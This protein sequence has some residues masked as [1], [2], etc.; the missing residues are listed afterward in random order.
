MAWKSASAIIW[1]RPENLHLRRTGLMTSDGVNHGTG[2][3]SGR[4][5]SGL[6]TGGAM[7]SSAAPGLQKIII[8]PAL[9]QLVGMHPA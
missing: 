1:V 3:M 8:Q 4:Q 7:P 6:L 2:R 9:T 5:V